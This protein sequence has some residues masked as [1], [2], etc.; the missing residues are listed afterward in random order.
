MSAPLE[1][2]IKRVKKRDGVPKE[3]VQRVINN[4]MLQNKKEKLSDFV[5][6]NDEKKLI[7]PQIIEILKILQ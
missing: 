5:I 2:R 3:H 6:Y 4:Q 1:I 7:L